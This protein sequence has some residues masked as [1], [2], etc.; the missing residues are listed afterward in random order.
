[1]K[2]TPL[3]VK[4]HACEPR[5]N[6]GVLHCTKVSD[7]KEATVNS[8]PNRQWPLTEK[9]SPVT[10]S[11]VPPASGPKDGRIMLTYASSVKEKSGP[12]TE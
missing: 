4:L 9:W 6:A 3:W 12:A 2:S 5:A 1:M 7:T 10:L 8:V 11:K